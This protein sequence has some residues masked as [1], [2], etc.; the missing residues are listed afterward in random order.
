MHVG[1]CP[2]APDTDIALTWRAAGDRIVAVERKPHRARLEV[3]VAVGHP[4][5][6]DAQDR[7]LLLVEKY[8]AEKFAKLQDVLRVRDHLRQVRLH[9]DRDPID[10]RR[11]HHQP[12]LAKRKLRHAA[13]VD[14]ACLADEEFV[15]LQD[16]VVAGLEEPP[17]RHPLVPRLRLGQAESAFAGGAGWESGFCTWAARARRQKQGSNHGEAGSAARNRR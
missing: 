13:E 7:L 8:V 2:D 10:R 4:R 1:R 16:L 6:A 11:A 17:D 3:F 9:H 12:R 15:G 5:K 14:V